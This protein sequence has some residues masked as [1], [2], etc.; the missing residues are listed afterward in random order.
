MPVPLRFR[1]ARLESTRT[2]R[3]ATVQ[4]EEAATLGSRQEQ[5]K[6]AGPHLQAAQA[7]VRTG[8]RVGHA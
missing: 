3:T 6:G 4:S 7:S 8:H 1:E 2:S 5:R